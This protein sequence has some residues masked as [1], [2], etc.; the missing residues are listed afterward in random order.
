[1][2][3]SYLNVLKKIATTNKLE[4]WSLL[5]VIK[6]TSSSSLKCQALQL[7]YNDWFCRLSVLYYLIC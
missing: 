6:K 7:N 2:I 4:S 3:Q 5:L 1:M